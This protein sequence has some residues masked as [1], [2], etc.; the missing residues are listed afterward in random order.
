MFAHFEKDLG[1]V[2]KKHTKLEEKYNNKKAELKDLSSDVKE[3]RVLTIRRRNSRIV[4]AR[5]RSGRRS[6]T[7]RRRSS[8]DSSTTSRSGRGCMT[9]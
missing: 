2:N 8:R 7:T 9:T 3:R 1:H 5:S 6:L 4:P